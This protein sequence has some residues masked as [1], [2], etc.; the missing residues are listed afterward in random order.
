MSNKLT[1]KYKNHS[2]V[3]KFMR[4][5]KVIFLYVTYALED[6]I[7][8]LP[9]DI[10]SLIQ[11]SDYKNKVIQRRFLN[12]IRAIKFLQLESDLTLEKLKRVHTIIMHQE[13]HPNGK[14]VLIREYRKTPASAGFKMF[15]PASAAEMLIN[16]AF[17]RYYSPNDNPISAATKLFADVINIHPFEDGNGRLCQVLISQVHVQS[18]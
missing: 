7:N 1:L 8:F 16:D 10:W 13:K 11:D 9:S 12:C 15:A 4:V 3:N 14:D 5:W 18:S 2:C 6:K 17:C